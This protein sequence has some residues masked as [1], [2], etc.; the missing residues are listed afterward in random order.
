MRISWAL[1]VAAVF[2]LVAVHPAVADSSS[3]SS[4]ENTIQAP[5]FDGN[6]Q[7]ID[8]PVLY[9][10]AAAPGSFHLEIVEDHVVSNNYARTGGLQFLRRRGDS[11][12]E[13]ERPHNRPGPSRS[14]KTDVAPSERHLEHEPKRRRPAH[15]TGPGEKHHPKPTPKPGHGKPGH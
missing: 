15:L 6:R 7:H 12:D 1:Q 13:H 11:S 3:S 9:K 10:R 14:D 4:D 2:C 8:D 5:I